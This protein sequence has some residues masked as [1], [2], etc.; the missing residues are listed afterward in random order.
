MAKALRIDEMVSVLANIDGADEAHQEL[1]HEADTLADRLAKEIA[2]RLNLVTGCVDSEAAYFYA[3]GPGQD[4]P[5]AFISADA[6]PEG[7]WETR[8]GTPAGETDEQ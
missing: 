8:D 5:Q 2:E 6:D 1:A 3:S 7:D 4:L